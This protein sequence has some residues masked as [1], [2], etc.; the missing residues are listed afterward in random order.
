MGE[1][2]L[3]LFIFKVRKMVMIF[4]FCLWGKGEWRLC[5]EI[6]TSLCT[7]CVLKNKHHFQSVA[8]ST[9]F[10]TDAIQCRHAAAGSAQDSNAHSLNQYNATLNED[11]KPYIC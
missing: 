11:A 8:C 4:L 10:R 9:A 7:G 1:I 2:I 3:T 5:K 6:L